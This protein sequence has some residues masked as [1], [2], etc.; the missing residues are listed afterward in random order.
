MRQSQ[1]TNMLLV[2]LVFLL[3][4]IAF[5][6][7]P[8][9]AYAAKK[10]T[11]KVVPVYEGTADQNMAKELEKEMQAGWDPAAAPMWQPDA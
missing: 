11:Y 3:G 5:R 4:M 2:V 7:D 10:F 9:P 1:V 6:S 8:V